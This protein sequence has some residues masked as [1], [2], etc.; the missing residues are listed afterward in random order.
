MEEEEIIIPEEEVF[1]YKSMRYILNGEGYLY[2]VSFGAEIS[3][4]LGNCTE[5]IGDIPEG[6]ETLQEWHDKEIEKL[7]AWKIV[8]GNLVFD[9]NKWNKLLEQYEID[10]ENNA[11]ATHQWVKSRLG[12]SNSVV[13]DEF[14]NNVTGTSLV[15]LEDSGDYEIPEVVLAS[16]TITGKVNVVSS[17]KNL[18]GIDA[19]TTTLNGVTFT[20]NADGT[21]TLKGTSTNSIELPLKGTSTSLDML[22]LIKENLNYSVGGLDNNVSL[23]LYKYDGTDRTLIGTYGNETFNLTSGSIVTQVTLKIPSGVTF[24]DVVISPQIEIGDDPTSFIK[25]SESKG[26]GT[27]NNNRATIDTLS[28]YSPFT[29]VMADKNIGLSID[30][31][32]FKSLENKFSE[33]EATEEGI[34]SQVNKTITD[35]NDLSEYVDTIESTIMEQT[36]EAFV[37]WFEKTGVQ[38]DLNAVKDILDGN[39]EDLNTITE[40]IRFEGA[41]ITLG[42]TDSQTK[43]VIKNDRISFITGETESAYISENTL[44]ITD[45]TILNKMLIGH[46]ETK[47]DEYGNLNTK[48]I[49]G[50]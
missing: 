40:Y 4:S 49:G 44:Y 13:I 34:K 11:L 12:A 38:N 24:N 6:Y 23:N 43:L 2:Q 16:E 25:H 29:I 46:W 28:S 21:I 39:T 42:R 3:C 19:V 7:N 9:A 22:F 30:Y 47:E 41:E 33:I 27:I 36:S 48:W 14:S 15:I 5:Y 8:D 26:S 45:S 18:L 10:A 50:N 17:N 31:Y 35:L 1:N 20:I 37:M 32:K